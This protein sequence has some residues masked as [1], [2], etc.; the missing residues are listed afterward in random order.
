MK[1]LPDEKNLLELLELAKHSE[2][3]AREMSEVAT[4]IAY[5]WQKKAEAKRK[6]A[7]QQF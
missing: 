4:N 3:K 7:R 1:E 6:A 5:K 2:R